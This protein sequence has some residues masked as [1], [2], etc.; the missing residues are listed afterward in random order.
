MKSEKVKIYVV[1]GNGATIRAYTDKAKAEE[2]AKY[3]TYCIECSGSYGSAY[4]KELIVDDD[5]EDE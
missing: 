4:V 3:Q 5:D 1:M 2:N